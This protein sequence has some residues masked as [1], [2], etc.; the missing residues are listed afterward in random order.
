M[1][2]CTSVFPL[3]LASLLGQAS[4]QCIN[5]CLNWNADGEC[6]D[7]GPGAEWASCPVGNDCADCGVRQA[8]PPPPPRYPVAECVTSSSS[9][10]L[11]VQ[12][13]YFAPTIVGGS[14]VEFA[15]QYYWLVSLQST[16][17]SHFCGGTL[18]SSTWVLSAA[19]CTFGTAA[20]SIIVKI[21]LHNRFDFSD[22]CVRKHT[23]KRIINHP[24]YSDNADAYDVSLLELNSPVDFP[25]ISSLN[26]GAVADGTL[27]TVAGWGALS[28]GGSSPAVPH[29]VQVPTVNQATC[30]SNYGGGITAAPFSAYR[31]EEMLLPLSSLAW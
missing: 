29:H 11:A 13:E 10:A 24:Q 4:A 6:D 28:S 16:G 12:P 3:L 15:R 5:D 25:P 20:S 18:I 26:E 1:L 9:S 31:Q 21:G 14:E 27:L 8:A 30:N 22:R 23:I 19:H 17:E 7:G 2:T